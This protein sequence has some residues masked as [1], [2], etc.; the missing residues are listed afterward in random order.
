MWLAGLINEEKPDYIVDG[1]DFDDFHSLCSHEGNETYKGKLKPSLQ[2]DIDAAHEA[3]ELISRN[4]THDCPKYIT[5]GNHEHRVWNYQDKNPEMYGI[6]VNM[7][8]D[9][10]NAHGWQYTMY[11]EYL[12]LAGV[13]FTH[14][15][16]NANGKPVQ[17]ETGCKQIAEKSIRDIC[18]GHT[19]KKDEWSAAKFGSA[20][21]VI[22]F[23][24]GCFMPDGYVPSYAKDTRKE[25]W[26]GCHVLMVRNGRIKSIKSYHMAE[27]Q[28]IY[29]QLP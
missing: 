8:L 9:V 1:G 17:S 14:V 3:R 11:G 18:Y 6:P 29:G 10:L 2:K 12:E 13:N 4:L 24:G 21:S 22:A 23:N 27:L 16:F 19:H 7:Y 20:L 15:P 28:E 25:F 26:Y 5:L